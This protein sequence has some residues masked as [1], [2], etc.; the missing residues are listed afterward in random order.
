M[1]IELLL[2]G[3]TVE[4]LRARI[5]PKSEISLQ[6]GQFDARSANPGYEVD[7]VPGTTVCDAIC[8]SPVSSLTH[9]CTWRRRDEEVR[10][11]FTFCE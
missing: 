6:H 7:P 11:T 9:S 5:D 10:K 3:V 8:M 1:L 4:V 2:L